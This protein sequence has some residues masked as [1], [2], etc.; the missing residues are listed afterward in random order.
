MIVE[1]LLS[2]LG[3]APSHAQESKR[4]IWGKF[5]TSLSIFRRQGNA[6]PL[7]FLSQALPTYD[8]VLQDGG[9]I[10]AQSDCRLRL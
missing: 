8:Y 2:K 1:E 10:H 7:S 5:S 3:G 6:R 9:Q 4:Q